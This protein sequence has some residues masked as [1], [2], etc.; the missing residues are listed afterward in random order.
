M[1]GLASFAHDPILP[2]HHDDNG[3]DFDGSCDGQDEQQLPQSS[4]NDGNG[5]NDADLDTN[6][7]LADV[8]GEDYFTEQ[9]SSKGDQPDNIPS[10]AQNSFSTNHVSSERLNNG[11]ERREDGTYNGVTTQPL[12]DQQRAQQA[13]REPMS[14]F[15]KNITPQNQDHEQQFLLDGSNH[16]SNGLGDSSLQANIAAVASMYNFQPS[17]NEQQA[18]MHDM[19]HYRDHQQQNSSTNFEQQQSQPQ[20]CQSQ[21]PHLDTQSLPQGNDSFAASRQLLKNNLQRAQQFNVMS[22]EKNYQHNQQQQDHP[23]PLRF[24]GGHS[25]QR[26]RVSP[27]TTAS[28]S[29]LTALYD[30]NSQNDVMKETV[31]VPQKTSS[32]GIIQLIDHEGEGRFNQAKRARVEGPTGISPASASNVARNQNMPGWMNGT[33]ASLPPQPSS[34]SLEL[35]RPNGNPTGYRPT[36]IYS[37]PT[38][39]TGRA[40]QHPPRM[41][42]IP[43]DFTPTWEAPLPRELYRRP[44]GRRRYELSLVNVMEFTITGLPISWE[45]PPSSLDG[46]RRKIKELSK[47]HGKATYERNKDGSDG[48]WRIPLVSAAKMKVHVVHSNHN[49]LLMTHFVHS[50]APTTPSSPIST[51]IRWSRLLGSRRISSKSPPSVRHG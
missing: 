42:E 25:I 29:Q 5:N 24:S 20:H 31:A 47:D 16:N 40:T 1:D 37:R 8:F 35:I 10:G 41:L 18:R 4:R 45:G 7:L 30:G 22:D 15:Q 39:P 23:P 12:S 21:Q 51:A 48:R 3:S 28:N 19:D 49:S 38:A 46:L 11:T 33:R 26:Q 32:N 6:E 27:T 17:G 44:V 13:E 34:R 2:L 50:R 36:P 14:A 43:P 9:I